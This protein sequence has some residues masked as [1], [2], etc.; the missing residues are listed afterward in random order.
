MKDI[1]L[2]ILVD[3]E[4]DYTINIDEDV[5]V[6][7]KLNVH[8]FT[9]NVSSVNELPPGI[10]VDYAVFFGNINNNVSDTNIQVEGLYNSDNGYVVNFSCS[11]NDL[12]RDDWN[13]VNIDLLCND[14]HFYTLKV[15]NPW[16][17]YNYGVMSPFNCSEKMYYEYSNGQ[18]ATFRYIPEQ[19]VNDFDTHFLEDTLYD[20]DLYD[21][22]RTQEYSDIV[23]IGCLDSENGDCYAFNSHPQLNFKPE[24]INVT[25]GSN[26]VITA[27]KSFIINFYSQDGELVYQTVEDNTTK[28][29]VLKVYSTESLYDAGIRYVI[30]DGIRYNIVEV[31]CIDTPNEGV[32]LADIGG[33]FYQFFLSSVSK[34]TKVDKRYYITSDSVRK[35]IDATLE[36][37]YSCKSSFVTNDLEKENIYMALTSSRRYILYYDYE[38][39][40]VILDDST[41]C[42]KK[43]YKNN[44]RKLVDYSFSLK[45]AKKR[46]VK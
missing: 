39:I 29:L 26:F 44:D 9:F 7:D 30:S 28:S 22:E 17:V 6:I 21:T 19:V 41:T 2:E 40:E 14:N 35:H 8:S 4:Y 33:V 3:D 37:I 42:K 24:V 34:D 12:M 13:F 46:V 31:N 20:I 1:E 32:L 25:L 45:A 11:I 10:S 5:K 16:N 27:R 23:Y 38:Y 36:D 43:T 18:V 15:F